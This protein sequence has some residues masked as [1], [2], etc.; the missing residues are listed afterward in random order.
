MANNQIAPTFL[1][2]ANNVSLS[3]NKWNDSRLHQN[4]GC[5]YNN[6]LS[7]FWK[8]KESFTGLPFQ[9]GND[10]YTLTDGTLYK[11][12]MAV[13]NNIP[14][15]YTYDV[16]SYEVLAAFS[17]YDGEH[18]YRFYRQADNTIQID[19]NGTVTD[20]GINEDF[21]AVKI[22][23]LPTKTGYQASF[24]MLTISKDTRITGT[25][26]NIHFQ[27][28]QNII[29]EISSQIISNVTAYSKYVI[30]GGLIMDGSWAGFSVFNN[31]G[32]INHTFTPTQF[33]INLNDFSKN[34]IILPS[35]L[36][37]TNGTSQLLYENLVNVQDLMLVFPD[38]D[39]GRFGVVNDYY[40]FDVVR[41]P[42]TYFYFCKFAEKGITVNSTW[43]PIYG[44]EMW[45]QNKTQL[46]NSSLQLGNR[47]TAIN[48]TSSKFEITIE[49]WQIAIPRK[50]YET[51]SELKGEYFG[52]YY[53]GSGFY[54]DNTNQYTTQQGQPI[55]NFWN[56]VHQKWQFNIACSSLITENFQENVYCGYHKTYFMNPVI[57]S[58]PWYEGLGYHYFKPGQR[59][60]YFSI[61]VRAA[62]GSPAVN[63][64]LN[65]Y[66]ASDF[67]NL[68]I[69][70]EIRDTDPILWEYTQETLS[71]DNSFYLAL[72]NSGEIQNVLSPKGCALMPWYSCDNYIFTEKN[73]IY[74]R[75]INN[76]KYFKITKCSAYIVNK[77][78]NY[79]L[80]N[81]DG[82]NAFNP[83]LNTLEK[84]W[85]IG[86][87]GRLS[88]PGDTHYQAYSD[89]S[90][91]FAYGSSMP[92][93]KV[94]AA[95]VNNHPEIT[96]DY[97][98]GIANEFLTYYAFYDYSVGNNPF[99]YD[100]EFYTSSGTNPVYNNSVYAQSS[101][102]YTN[103]ELQ[104]QSYVFP[105]NDN[106]YPYFLCNFSYEY[107]FNRFGAINLGNNQMANIRYLQET[108]QVNNYSLKALLDFVENVFIVQG[109]IYMIKSGF[110]F[111]VILNPDF[112]ISYQNPIT[113]CKNLIFC[114]NTSK[115]AFFYSPLTKGFYRFNGSQI[116]EYL[117]D[118]SD[119]VNIITYKNNY[120]MNV[121]LI[122]FLDAEGHNKVL[123]IQG[124]YSVICWEDT[125]D[126]DELSEGNISNIVIEKDRIYLVTTQQNVYSIM[127][128][129]NKEN[130]TKLR[131]EYESETLLNDFSQNIID[132]VYV[133]VMKKG[134]PYGKVW[135]SLVSGS[136]ETKQEFNLKELLED[137][138]GL[139]LI[140][141][142]PKFQQ[143]GRVAIR[144]ESEV[145]VENIAYTV[146]TV[147]NEIS[148]KR[149]EI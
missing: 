144:V 82:L 63:Y 22:I 136:G 84:C 53:P 112:S 23:Q 61:G 109:Q 123:M 31:T 129:D 57:P 116:F 20:L 132:C 135:V 41:R 124:D 139:S 54:A 77:F 140:R 74:G 26:R 36:D 97:F 46:Y 94:S 4:K 66:T 93:V 115:Y 37:V 6:L 146:K 95:T 145:P 33:I 88:W 131:L 7:P 114:G 16:L 17:N 110:I 43:F 73:V 92:S 11:N 2:F 79:L 81:S 12:E 14:D 141:Y 10:V 86:Y 39:Y 24:G 28:S 65:V 34:G 8:R 78:N 68:Q 87:N 83:V 99:V 143:R 102:T 27:D 147:G 91:Y 121:S 120:Y 47:I 49:S 100:I 130:F 56:T 127:F 13:L 19:F 107:F 117:Q 30:I 142:Q 138:N 55:Q 128:Y 126:L 149:I 89:F 67:K 108:I 113:E 38:D 96:L 85:S 59:E 64:R 105:D 90:L 103:I 69:D 40:Q 50:C 80:I 52:T 119:V 42:K 51:R 62:N 9:D 15:G 70:T 44:F 98:S 71:S 32:W 75:F 1:N 48:K 45:I 21:A 125:D 35:N 58:D 76:N 60:D 101:Q 118:A 29:I 122:S 111:N 106:L 25:W 104:A 18:N 133:N 5:Y 134:L 72:T 148:H 3:Q 137:R